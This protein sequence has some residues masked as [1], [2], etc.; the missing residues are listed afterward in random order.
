VLGV[1]V[2]DKPFPAGRAGTWRASFVSDELRVL[3]TNANNVF[4]L[5]KDD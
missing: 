1:T 2:I 5:V 3:H 4:V